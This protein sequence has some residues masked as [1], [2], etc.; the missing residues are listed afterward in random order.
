[1]ADM[2][3]DGIPEELVASWD[4]SIISLDGETGPVNWRTP[5]GNLNGGDVWTIDNC[6]DIDGDGID[7][8][9]AGS[10]DYNVYLC[11][12][13]DGS[14][15]WQY[16]TGNRL[17]SVRPAGDLDGDGKCDIIAGTQY[18]YTPNSGKMFA[19][20]G[21]EGSDIDINMIPDNPPV[22]VPVGGHFTYTGEITNNTP[23]PVTTDV[24]IMLKLPGGAVFGPVQQFNNI[25]LAGNHSISVP[26]IN[27]YVPWFAPL[28]TYDYIAYCGDYPGVIVDSSKF[29]FLTV[30]QSD[31]EQTVYN[32]WQLNGWTDGLQNP[33]NGSPNPQPRPV[34]FALHGNYPNP[35][36]VSTNINFTLTY[37]GNV[38]LS[39]YDI[40]GRQV[41]VL[42]DNY[43]S[44][45][46]HS[47]NFNADNL[48][49]GIYYARL[50]H[51]GK[52]LTSTM[53]LVK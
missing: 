40:M 24:W 7:E 17:K 21:G 47:I 31:A 18:T 45:G 52:T 10:F 16:N 14:I 42:V 38:H 41:V 1:M 32:D 8:V 22:I 36:N 11:S 20:S 39:V 46:T 26:G 23:G 19:I 48:P 30:I 2:N 37:G 15:L 27:Q 34:E 3:G 13:V 12:G 4:N 49:S 44:E 43:L 50:S 35:F 5:V 25:V 9:V 29:E 51:K 6:P 33:E 53:T 28:G